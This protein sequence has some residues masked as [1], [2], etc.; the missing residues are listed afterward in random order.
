MSCLPLIGVTDCSKQSYCH[1]YLGVAD[2]HLRSL[3]AVVDNLPRMTPRSGD[4][5]GRSV[6][7]SGQSSSR[8]IACTALHYHRGVRNAPTTDQTAAHIPMYFIKAAITAGVPLIAHPRGSQAVGEAVAV[9]LR[10][11]SDDL[12]APS[13]EG[14]VNLD[15]LLQK[16]LYSHSY[17]LL[18]PS[19]ASASRR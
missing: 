1:C 3:D 5:L 12:A 9:D 17:G 10:P 18:L 19:G 7:P 11:T 16:Q 8:S 2:K 14:V 6:N 15:L 13:Y 4:S